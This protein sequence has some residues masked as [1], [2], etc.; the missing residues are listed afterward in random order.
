MNFIKGHTSIFKNFI[1]GLTI[2]AFGL[3]MT[4]NAAAQDEGEE[5]SAKGDAVLEEI[6]IYRYSGYKRRFRITDTV[7]CNR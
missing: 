4:P 2:V 7:D 1:A 6:L 5:T 3:G